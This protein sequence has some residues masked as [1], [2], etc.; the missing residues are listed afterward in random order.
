M[1]QKFHSWYNPTEMCT[2]VHQYVQCSWKLNSI[3]PKGPGN[4]LD[5]Q[6][7]SEYM[8]YILTMGNYT[9]LKMDHCY[10]TQK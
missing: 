3:E 9:A 4:N 5:V 8:W 7:Q 10:R 2:C 6:Q 1:T